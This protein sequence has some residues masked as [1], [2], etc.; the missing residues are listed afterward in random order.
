[1]LPKIKTDLDQ[2]E[3]LASDFHNDGYHNNAYHL[4]S[5]VMDIQNLRDQ[6][7]VALMIYQST[8]KD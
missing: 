8:N 6:L 4:R 3:A 7:A 2:L 1:M 5:A